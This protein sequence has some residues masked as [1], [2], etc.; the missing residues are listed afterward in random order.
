MLD[1]EV[2]Y[3]KSKKKHTKKVWASS[4]WEQ[5]RLVVT[6]EE[7]IQQIKERYDLRSATEFRITKVLGAV[8]LGERYGQAQEGLL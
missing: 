2:S 3:T 4:R 5:Y 6:D 1:L 7:C 8:Y